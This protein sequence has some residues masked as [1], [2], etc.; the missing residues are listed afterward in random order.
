MRRAIKEKNVKRHIYSGVITKTLKTLIYN[1]LNNQ[2]CINVA[3][4]LFLLTCLHFI[5][6]NNFS[7]KVLYVHYRKQKIKKNVKNKIKIT[8]KH[9]TVR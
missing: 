5:F 2:T 4:V 8:Y 1:T 7:M 9:N 3:N 6:K